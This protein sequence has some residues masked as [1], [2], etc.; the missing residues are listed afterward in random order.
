MTR[1]VLDPHYEIA[2][3]QVAQFNRDGFIILRDVLTADEVAFY[4]QAIT[5]TAERIFADQ[6]N[7]LSFEGAFHQAQ[8]L[9]LQSSDVAGF[10]LAPRLGKIASRLMQV[11]K[12]RIYHDQALFKPGGAA[13]SYWHQDQYFWPLDTPISLGL[14]LPL[15]DVSQDMGPMRYVRGSHRLGDQ[16]QHTINAESEAFFEGLI[17]AHKL[18]VVEDN[19]MKAGDCAFHTGWTVHGAL[20]NQSDKRRDAMVVTFYP[21]GTRLTE[22]KNGY[23][24]YD[25]KT[26]LGG[27]VPG[28]L[29]DSPLNPLVWS[30]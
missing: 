5:E 4:R 10:C 13:P 16:G 29:A 28:D 15:V 21:D 23:Q 25:A 11:D 14:W 30:A 2:D 9:R 6:N 18:D 22:F 20:G 3:D 17:K 19:S 12:A 1:P 27:K 7:E 8:N 24:A 26:F